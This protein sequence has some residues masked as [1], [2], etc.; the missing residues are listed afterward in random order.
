MPRINLTV[1]CDQQTKA[2]RL[3]PQGS[4]TLQRDGMLLLCVRQESVT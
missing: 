1:L 4:P 3:E 2:K